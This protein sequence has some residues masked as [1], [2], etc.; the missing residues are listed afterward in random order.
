MMLALTA[1]SAALAQAIPEPDPA[2]R[3]YEEGRWSDAIREYR[4][5]LAEN[6]DAG[7]GWLRVAQ[8]EREL[9]RYEDALE[10][11]DIAELATGPEAMVHAERAR[12]L[13]HLG[14]RDEALA[15]LET[16]DHLELRARELL[17][18]DPVFDPLRE[19]SRFQRVS[20]SV[21]ARVHP[22]EGIEAAGD[23]DFWLGRWEV[24]GPGGQLLGHNTITREAGGCVIR[25]SWEGAP[26][27]TGSSMTFYLP[28][29][30]QWRHV[31]IGSGGTHI[32]MTG[33]PGEGGMHLEGT[34]E[35]LEAEEVVAFR[36]TWSELGDGS[37][38]QLMEQFDL[39]TRSWQAWY[40]GYY[41][42]LD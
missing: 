2:L 25:E 20:R 41:R 17:E 27:S 21:R 8:S 40:D 18:E 37:V 35:Y 34:I 39:T 10:T 32:D 23:F 28:S 12:N 24:R 9:G 11:L 4:A 38:R 15:A 33:G 19:D 29:R 31:W 6:P 14:R 5:L 7:L 22:C 16:A 42:R 1:S 26:G 36:A 3:A 13:L 30:K